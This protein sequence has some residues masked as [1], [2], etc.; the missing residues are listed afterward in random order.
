MSRPKKRKEKMKNLLKRLSLVP[1]GIRYKLII[2]FCLM[3]FIPFLV[4]IY[5]ASVYVFPYLEE[6]GDFTNLKSISLMVICGGLLAL[7]GYYLAKGIIEPIIKIALDARLIANGDIYRKIEAKG[8]DEIGI[9]SLSLNQITDKVRQ[10]MEE[11]RSYQGKIKG[12]NIDI[13]RKISILSSLLHIGSLISDSCEVDKVLDIIIGELF[14]MH[15]VANTFL[16]LPE[17]KTGELVMRFV[18]GSSAGHLKELRLKIGEGLLGRIFYTGETII[19][20]NNHPSSKEVKDFEVQYDLKNLLLMP[21]ASRGEKVALLGTGSATE[22]Y[23][24]SDDDLETLRLF[25]QQISIAIENDMLTR[26]AEELKMRDDVTGLYNARYLTERLDEEVRRAILYQRP[27]SLIVFSIDDFNEHL[28]SCGK[29][30]LSEALKMIAMILREN[31]EEPDKPVRFDKGTF[32]LLLPERNKKEAYYIAE[33]VRKTVRDATFAWAEGKGIT[34][35]GGVSENPIDGVSGKELL[36]KAREALEAA[37]R[38]GRD[39]I[40]NFGVEV[41]D[42]G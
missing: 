18:N 26:L 16:L 28:E 6:I 42:D 13:N 17:K 20:D 39:T 33:E 14:R 5:L 2:S 24:Y 19:H 25:V 35:S 9:L 30:R 29:E 7:L 38:G 1:R 37:I 15:E 34:V 31:V 36:N 41:K 4:C 10:N 21:V 8:E 3:S 32:C 40:V 27:C 23:L 22:G 12:I 11:L